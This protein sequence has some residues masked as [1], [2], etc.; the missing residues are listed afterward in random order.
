MRGHWLS[1]VLLLGACPL[2][3][4]DFGLGEDDGATGT[5]SGSGTTSAGMGSTG[6]G[7]T[8][9]ASSGGTSSGAESSG[10]D[11]TTAAGSSGSSGS[12]GGCVPQMVSIPANGDGFFIRG[13]GPVGDCAWEGA[14]SAVG[15]KKLNF[16]AIDYL[17]VGHDTLVESVFVAH[18]PV[19]A[20]L[21]EL[22]VDPALADAVAT[23]RLNVSGELTGIDPQP[24]LSV[25]R[26][27]ADDVWDEGAQIGAPA[28][29]GDSCFAF[30]QMVGG[31][32][33]AWAVPEQGP[34]GAAEAAGQAT[35]DAAPLDHVTV[36][37]AVDIGPWLAA[38]AMGQDT[39]RGFVVRLETEAMGPLALVKTREAGDPA[40]H[41]SLDVW[42]CQ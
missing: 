32:Q 2:P 31:N 10:A 35:L 11:A 41:P 36:P 21:S 17:A 13:T 27:G 28:G 18:F 25:S 14:V 39:N 42:Y 9:N 16:G 37:I 38:Q 24:V 29:N 33:V 34:L 15:C 20:T 19:A 6:G 23:L 1:L 30:R 3:N 22:G 12:T 40:L 7:S 5:D 26:I 8:T 4:P